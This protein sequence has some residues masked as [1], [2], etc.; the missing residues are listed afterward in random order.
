MIFTHVFVKT[1]TD[2]EGGAN[3]VNKYEAT[4]LF[5]FNKHHILFRF[6]RLMAPH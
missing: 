1:E 6:H 3:S 4:G 2:R 5:S